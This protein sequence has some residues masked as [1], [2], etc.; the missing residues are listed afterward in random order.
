MR[1]ARRSAIVAAALSTV[2]AAARNPV[3]GRPEPR[4]TRLVAWVLLITGVLR[5]GI[6]YVSR[7]TR[8]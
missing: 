1:S 5:T 2:V 8:A 6:S 4:R 7:P 3:E